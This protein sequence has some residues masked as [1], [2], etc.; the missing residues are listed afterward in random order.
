MT[1]DPVIGLA[2]ALAFVTALGIIALGAV[3]FFDQGTRYKYPPC[4]P[5]TVN[6]MFTSCDQRSAKEHHFGANIGERSGR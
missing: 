2:I 3:G 1:R 5:G 6:A 4:H